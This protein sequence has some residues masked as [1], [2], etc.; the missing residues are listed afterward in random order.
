M[1]LLLVSMLTVSNFHSDLLKH[2]LKITLRMYRDFFIKA[3]FIIIFILN[4]EALSQ[5]Q[6]VMNTLCINVHM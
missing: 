6:M 4:K 2:F 5:D 1:M 3:K